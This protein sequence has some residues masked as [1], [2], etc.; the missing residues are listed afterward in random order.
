MALGGSSPPGCCVVAPPS[1]V[2]GQSLGVGGGKGRV[3]GLGVGTGR[4]ISEVFFLNFFFVIFCGEG[5]G[6]YFFFLLILFY[7][8]FHS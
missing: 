6:V 4:W 2:P 7:Y 1:A 3:G 5:G 8:Y